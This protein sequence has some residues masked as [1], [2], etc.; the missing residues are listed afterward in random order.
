MEAE[1]LALLE[2]LQK[3]AKLNHWR[4][5]LCTDAQLTIKF[6]KDDSLIPWQLQAVISNIKPLFD[7]VFVNNITYVLREANIVAHKSC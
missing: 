4:V 7:I 3:M 6:L 5:Q 1:C 2:G